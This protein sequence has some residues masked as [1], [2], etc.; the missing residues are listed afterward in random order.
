MA[1]IAAKNT[2]T[3]RFFNLVIAERTEVGRAHR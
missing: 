2:L 3:G 1:H